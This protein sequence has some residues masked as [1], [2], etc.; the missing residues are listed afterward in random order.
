MWGRAQSL[1]YLGTER[2]CPVMSTGFSDAGVKLEQGWQAASAGGLRALPLCSWAA[3][4]GTQ[5]WDSAGMWGR[6]WDRTASQSR[7]R[8][9]GDS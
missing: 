3:S 9:A 7:V 8:P 2:V 4:C 1:G 5:S 6:E